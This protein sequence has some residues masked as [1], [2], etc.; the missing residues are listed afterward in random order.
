MLKDQDAKGC[1]THRE[2][3][4][5][6]RQSQQ[7]RRETV[8]HLRIGWIQD[9][10]QASNSTVR[11]RLEAGLVAHVALKKPLITAVHRR[12]RL[13]FAM[14][15]ADWTWLIGQLCFGVMSQDSL[16]FKMMVG[17]LWGEDPMKHTETV[18]LYPQWNLVV[19]LWLCGVQCCTEE[20]G[21]SLH[22]KATLT[23]M[24]IWIFSGTLPFPQHI[25]W[26][27]E[28]T[29]FSKTM[30]PHATELTLSSMGN[31][32][33]TCIVWNGHHRVLISIQ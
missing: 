3:R 21:F 19:A 16:S 28:I 25:F 24:A 27:M 32:T 29:L 30:V 8:P 22:W 23:R 10:I 11:R 2:D 15:H 6:V 14:A 20:L 7:N 9:G 12:K 26:D 18:V 4:L 17:C 31:L 13:R 33:K 5:L 1:L